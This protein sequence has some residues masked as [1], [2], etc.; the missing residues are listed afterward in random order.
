MAGLVVTANEVQQHDNFQIEERFKQVMATGVDER[1]RAKQRQ[2]G[3][4]ACQLSAD[5]TGN[6]VNDQRYA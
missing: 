4:S 1:W 6:D 2:Y 3:H 5:L